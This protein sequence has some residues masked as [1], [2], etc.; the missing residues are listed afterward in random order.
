MKRA[1][2]IADAAEQAL[3]TLG[4][5]ASA[6]EI[7]AEILNAGLYKFNTPTPVL[8]VETELKRY[9]VDSPRSDH[10]DKPRFR[11]NPDR[12]YCMAKGESPTSKKSQALGM[13]RIMRASDKEELIEELMSNHVGVF[14]EIWRLLL[15]TAQVGM[16]AKRR[17]PLK[18]IEAGKGIDQATFGNSSSW[19]GI[20]YLMG[21]AESGDSRMIEGNSDGEDQRIQLFQEY[22]N[23]GLSILKEFF[24]GR[25]INTEGMIAFIESHQTGKGQ[26]D[27]VDLDLSI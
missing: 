23:G 3:K 12:T 16:K 9:S 18:A 10:R 26:L 5:A 19:P 25:P 4:R 14:R 13:K 6:E 8:V 22:A 2:T 21:L 11:I 1:G 20:L 27:A 17:E 15:F 24:Q 7:H